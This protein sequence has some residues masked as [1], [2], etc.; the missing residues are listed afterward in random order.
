MGITVLLSLGSAAGYVVATFVMKHWDAIGS[1]KAAVFVAAALAGAVLLETEAL[2][3]ARFAY[4][5]IV[6]LGFESSL[7]LLCGWILLRESYAFHQVLGLLL[8]VAGVAI[9]RWASGAD[10][11][12]TIAG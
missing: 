12:G 5:A 8:I 4:V 10:A 2:R 3:Q 11:A 7:A 1:A 6:I 9:T